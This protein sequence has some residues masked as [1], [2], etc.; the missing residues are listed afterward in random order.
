M[1]SSDFGQHSAGNLK[2]AAR[3]VE[4]ALEFPILNLPST[5]SR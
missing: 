5:F 4:I 2:C 3:G 1:S